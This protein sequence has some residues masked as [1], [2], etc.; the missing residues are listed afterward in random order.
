MQNHLKIA[1]IGDPHFCS[2]RQPDSSEY[3]LNRLDLFEDSPW[4]TLTK[5]VKQKAITADILVC[6]GDMTLRSDAVALKRCWKELVG[7]AKHLQAKVLVST[8]GNHDVHSVIDMEFS[9]GTEGF[10]A[11]DFHRGLFEDLKLLSPPFPFVEFNEGCECIHEEL[12]TQYFGENLA[13][14]ERKEYVILSYNSCAEHGH[15]LFER[16]RGTFPE[17]SKNYLEA[18]LKNMST[19]KNVP[20][21]LVLHH[22]LF[23]LSGNKTGSCDFVH[24][25]D[26]FIK[27]L[28]D[29]SRNWLIIN[30][31]KHYPHLCYAQGG[32]GSPVVFSAASLGVPCLNDRT[33]KDSSL[34][35][36]IVDLHPHEYR[37]QGTIAINQWSS[38]CGWE[39]LPYALL[40]FGEREDTRSIA[41][42]IAKFFAEQNVSCLNWK[43]IEEHFKELQFILPAD[44]EKLMLILNETYSLGIDPPKSG[45]FI[46]LQSQSA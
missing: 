44:H 33:F 21:I 38:G 1:V 32:S 11:L 6:V 23:S 19:S 35:F 9:K 27:I 42:R 20:H 14:M 15:A 17:S 41:K 18:S 29:S 34:Q 16:E 40:G 25:G 12:R 13:I 7:M 45:N 3:S 28:E 46:R 8:A 5:Y 4:A 22:P 2:T 31:H 43:T 10:R 26:S 30:G 36:Y 37:M 39:E 24:Q